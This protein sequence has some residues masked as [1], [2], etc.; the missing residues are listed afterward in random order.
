MVYSIIFLVSFLISIVLIVLLYRV[1]N[2]HITRRLI[3]GAILVS[4]WLLMEA[5][6]YYVKNIE[7]VIFF[8]RAKFFSIIF[9]PPLYVLTAYEYAYK[10]EKFPQYALIIFV[11]PL[12]SLLA[13]ITNDFPYSFASNIQ[14][15]YLDG[16]PIFTFTPGISYWIHTYYSY[17]N[18]L[19]VC[20]IL[21]L[22]A[23]R[24]P[25]LYRRQST[26][27]FA[28]SIISFSINVVAISLGSTFFDMTS[29][30]ILTTLVVFYWGI[31]RLPNAVIKP[32]ARDLVIENIK[33]IVVILDSSDRIIDINP[34][35]MQFIRT[36]GKP[37]R[38]Q[39]TLQEMDFD[40]IKMI[41]AMKIF[42]GFRTL[43]STLNPNDSSILTL[44][45][46]GKIFY[47]RVDSS[48][49]VDTDGSQI[50]R[51]F[52]LHD[53]TK[54]QEYMNNLKYL[55]EELVISDR[56]INDALEGIYI[57]DAG[58]NIIRINNSFEKMSGYTIEDLIGQ[59]P[60]LFKSGRHKKKFY[61][62]MWHDLIAKGYWEGEIWNRKKNGEIF[63]NRM[64][65][66]ALKKSSGA[67]ENYICISSDISKIKKAEEDLQYLAYYDS[68]T[69]IPNR[70][71]FN[72]RLERALSR[73][74]RNKKSVALLFMDL[75]G[76]KVINDSLGHAI[77]DLLLKEVAYRI[78]SSIRE[79][80]TVSRFGGDEFTV[81]LEDI[82]Q[83]ENAR[84]VAENLIKQIRRPYFVVNRELT[85]GVSIG[86]SLSPRD[87]ITTEGLVRKAD[88]AMYDAKSAG[89]GRYSFSSAEIEKRNQETLEMQL[90][91][92]KALVNH[93]FILNLQPQIAFVGDGFKVIGAEALIRWNTQNGFQFTPDKFIP[94]SESNGL[95]KPIGDWV[96]EEIF[97]IDRALKENGIHIK[98][99]I[100]VSSKQFENGTF[101]SKIK[102]VIAENS[103]QNIELV[104]EITESFL[105]QELEKSIACLLEIKALG[106][107][108]AL[109]DFGTGFSSLSYLTN[110]PIDYLKIDKSFVDDI[111]NP[112]RKNLTSS[113]ISM[114]KTL[115]L[116]TVAEGVE[117]SSQISSLKNEGCDVL[118]GY[119]FSKPLEM[120]AFIEYVRTEIPNPQETT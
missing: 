51:L 47:F 32:F 80:D 46:D 10:K 55:N 45:S 115:E 37:D 38:D 92:G 83:D 40:G 105:L 22:Y 117:T 119:Y 89:R 11:V 72:H 95:I 96:L 19:L 110:L 3:I 2:V 50:G 93:E 97:R 27:I 79:S 102:E 49:I 34:A 24:S 43:A 85:L 9:I 113:I 98:L 111:A 86:I 42:P 54:M 16:R 18:I 112:Q 52:M 77:G 68:L 74:K 7:L 71:Y 33:D 70:V 31:F 103:S 59:N 84:I 106:I 17:S 87:D 69:G 65:I 58:S 29:I 67:V 118:Q 62:E 28:G 39:A 116:Q 81:I 82:T 109:D 66:T 20:V 44:D 6:C 1:R 15:V 13:L 53:I 26:F 101:V 73:A 30:S 12:L 76:F 107:G 25:K 114:A 23:I 91:L 56:I 8:Q 5:L 14:R 48:P 88:A 64:S 60:R 104:F 35:A 57:T 90:M 78:K 41:E 108:I 99:A 100:N 63:P 75:D 21:L 120:S 94:L 61:T 36:F 4:F